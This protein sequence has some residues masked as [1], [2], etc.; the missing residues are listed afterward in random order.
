MRQLQ[1]LIYL[2]IQYLCFVV[3]VDA[4]SGPALQF[5][6]STAT[7]VMLDLIQ[8]HIACC[9]CSV[10]RYIYLMYHDP[11]RKGMYF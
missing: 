2:P 1:Q 6:L 5:T 8:F 11:D 3:S 4:F 10:H 9:L 7:I